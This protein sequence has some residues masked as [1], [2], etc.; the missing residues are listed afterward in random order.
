MFV[1]T[2]FD[3][4][5][6]HPR[7]FPP[8][9]SIVAKKSLQ[10]S[11]LGPFMAISGTVFIDRGNGPQAVRSLAAAGE[12]MKSRGTS[13]W[14]FPEGTRTNQ[15][16]PSMLPFKKGAFYLAVQSGIPIVPVVVENYWKIYRPG[17]FGRGTIKVRGRQELCRNK[18]GC[19]S[20]IYCQSFH[21]FRPRISARQT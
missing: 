13:L 19:C 17:F 15:E 12:K 6:P 11:P 9:T 14:M 3:N 1:H 8:R 7:V 10:W 21:L 16:T 4:L 18:R 5:I 20:I 2:D